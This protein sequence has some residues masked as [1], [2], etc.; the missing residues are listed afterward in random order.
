MLFQTLTVL[1]N[2]CT[3]YKILSVHRPTAGG[4]PTYDG[5]GF[6]HIFKARPLNKKVMRRQ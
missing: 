2:S 4:A 3:N 1:L 6:T 5:L